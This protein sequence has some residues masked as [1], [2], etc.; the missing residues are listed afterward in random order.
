LINSAGTAE[1]Y[2]DQW[3]AGYG[4]TVGGYLKTLNGNCGNGYTGDFIEPGT[5]PDQCS[6]A[7]NDETCDES[8]IVIEG[9]YWS[10][11]TYLGA[12]Y[13]SGT[14]AFGEWLVFTPDS[15]M[16]PPL[17]T[18]GTMEGRAPDLHNL[19]SDRSPTY[20]KWLPTKVPDGNYGSTPAIVEPTCA[21]SVSNIWDVLGLMFGL[22]PHPVAMFAAW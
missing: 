9:I 7:Y 4:S 18:Y 5:R 2:P 17:D 8:C 1:L 14:R 22:F 6:Y 12:Q 19:L 10:L 20:G 13:Y 3:L 16:S 11:T 15:G 21:E